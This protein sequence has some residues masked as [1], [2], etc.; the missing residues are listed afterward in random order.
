MVATI[1][2]GVFGAAVPRMHGLRTTGAGRSFET[3]VKL[4]QRVRDR[5]HAVRRA[6]TM[7]VAAGV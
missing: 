2:R 4:V 7:H 1:P 6:D 5:L 3:T